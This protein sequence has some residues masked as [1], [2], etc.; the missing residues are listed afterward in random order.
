VAEENQ[1]AVNV[2]VNAR[3]AMISKALFGNGKPQESLLTRVAFLESRMS[4]VL[5]LAVATFLGVA[6]LVGNAIVAIA[7]KQ[8]SG[9]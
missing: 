3:L 9:G 5:K 7:M 8:I 6:G 1:T 2:D 4:L